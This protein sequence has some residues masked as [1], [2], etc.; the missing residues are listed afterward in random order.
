MA[1]KEKTDDEIADELL[2]Q[3][4]DVVKM[5]KKRKISSKS[6][7]SRFMQSLTSTLKEYMSSFVIIG[8]DVNEN[9][10]GF[11]HS[12]SPM[13]HEATMRLLEKVS[14]NLL[15]AEQSSGSEDNE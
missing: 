15:Y 2:S 13:Q 7:R 14:N 8:Y 12:E 9:H 6:Q 4:P 1:K 5:P 3:V 10:V 11:M